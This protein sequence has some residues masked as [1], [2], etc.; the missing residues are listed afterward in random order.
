MQKL[1]LLKRHP[2][3]ALNQADTRGCTPLHLALLSGSVG[4]TQ[5]LLASGAQL[6]RCAG[7]PVTCLAVCQGLLPG[8]EEAAVKLLALLLAAGAN[9][10]EGDDGGR[11][12]LH[13]AGAAGLAECVGP[14]T[15]AAA[16]GDKQ[17]LAQWEEDAQVRTWV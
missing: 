9:A 3:A 16:A 7:N 11:T 14:L 1:A 12:A 15:V 2:V 4:C 10:R 13:W 5:L 8:R 17:R 6:K